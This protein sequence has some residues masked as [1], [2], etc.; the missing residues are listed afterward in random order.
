MSETPPTQYVA[1]PRTSPANY[2]SPEQLEAL[3]EGY[4]GLNKVFLV[5][6]VLILF[7]M[8]VGLPIGFAGRY[9]GLIFSS[10]VV[11]FLLYRQ[12]QKIAFGKNWT[13][14]TTIGITIAMT[15]FNVIPCIGLF[16]Y[17]AMQTV[18]Q[19]EIKKYGVRPGP[20]GIRQKDVKAV[21]YSRRSTDPNAAQPYHP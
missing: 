14:S 13:K 8:F 5:E 7:V 20:F 18:A 15:I 1:Y 16:G 17:V 4:R 12:N 11:G 21:V 9:A 19:N 10:C 3:W 6:I 2:G